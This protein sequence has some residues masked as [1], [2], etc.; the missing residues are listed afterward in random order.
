MKMKREEEGLDGEREN[1]ETVVEFM[2]QVNAMID[3]DLDDRAEHERRVH[4]DMLRVA[5]LES[6]R[7]QENRVGDFGR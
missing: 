1:A 5:L 3:H 7:V 4:G 2:R 6:P